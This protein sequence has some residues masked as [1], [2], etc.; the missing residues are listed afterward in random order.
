MSIQGGIFH[1]CG[2]EWFKLIS[3]KYLI[4]H[5]YCKKDEK[6]RD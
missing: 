1:H 2:G 5:I 3:F 4:E 6:N